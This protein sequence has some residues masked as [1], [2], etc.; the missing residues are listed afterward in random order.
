MRFSG[1][2]LPFL[3]VK[4]LDLICV[5]S[6]QEIAITFLILQDSGVHSDEEPD[7]DEGGKLAPFLFLVMNL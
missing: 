1:A 6:P 4:F 2:H 5:A 7:N 3:Q